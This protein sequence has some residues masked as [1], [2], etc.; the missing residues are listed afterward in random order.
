M[1]PTT[2]ALLNGLLSAALVLL[3]ILLKP[4]MEIWLKQRR[5][6]ISIEEKWQDEEMQSQRTLIKA[7]SEL[8]QTNKE[9]VESNR[10]VI[11]GQA[12]LTKVY[13]LFDEFIGLVAKKEET[14]SQLL[15]AFEAFKK[16]VV[17]QGERQLTDHRNIRDALDDLYYL[18]LEIDLMLKP[19][20]QHQP[21]SSAESSSSLS[22]VK[23]EKKGTGELPALILPA[24]P[25]M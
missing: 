5:S 15:L 20:Y 3:S 4:R 6:N 17:G 22:V 9:L 11:L 1:D 8:A 19:K 18:L 24:E 2:G 12:E 13:S 25:S 23:R 10:E 14:D 21:S 16:T 7:I